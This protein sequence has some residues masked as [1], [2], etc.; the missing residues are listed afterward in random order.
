MNSSITTSAQMP[1]SNILSL[2]R[3]IPLIAGMVCILVLIWANAFPTNNAPHSPLPTRVQVI[4]LTAAVFLIAWGVAGSPR[5]SLK[6]IGWREVA[7]VLVITLA[8]LLIRLWGLDD[9]LRL[10]LD[11]SNFVA[12]A[13]GALD[14]PNILLYFPMSGISPYTWLYPMTQADMTLIFGRNL[15]GLRAASAVLGAANVAAVYL[16]VRALYNRKMAV[17]AS[18]VFAT[19]PVH[20][21]FSRIALLQP[22]DT[23]MGTLALAFVAR[24]LKTRHPLDWGI[25]GV[26]LGL[27]HYY[28]E[29]GRLLFTPF[30]AIWLG[31]LMLTHPDSRTAIRG[32]VLRLVFASFLIAIPVYTTILA[33]DRPLTGRLDSSGVGGLSYWTN[34]VQDGITDGEQEDAIYRLTSPFLFIVARPE[35]NNVY[36]GGTQPLVMHVLV[37]F[38]AVGVVVTLTKWRKPQILPAAWL[39]SV[40]VANALLIRESATSPRYIVV[41]PALAILIALGIVA[42]GG[43]LERLNRRRLAWVVMTALTIAAAVVQTVYYF[44]PHLDYL[45]YQHRVG[46]SYGDVWDA[47]M[48]MNADL[49]HDTQG[50]YI[51]KPNPPHDESSGFLNY[52]Q[53]GNAYSFRTYD[54]G[55]VTPKLLRS[56]PRQRGY[57]FFVEARHEGILPLL[58]RYFPDAEPPRYST[59]D[60][61]PREEYILVYVP[62]L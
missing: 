7:V 59:T 26:A 58:Y 12:G 4:L 42:I 16:L 24:G 1:K 45:N 25:A 62:P 35:A 60:I 34:L 38:F 5:L 6:N 61:A 48:R 9:T 18:I 37:P 21:H 11:E 56:L 51:G 20:L 39:L 31:W 3:Y 53:D 50:F 44:G 2:R 28:F 29:A 41:T 55:S 46:L 14:E 32:G 15:T 10:L 52:L 23:L 57:A 47:V 17:I 13:D 33:F 43:V 8:A 54:P 19:L 40:L 27:T 22:G 36:F 30:I 49:P